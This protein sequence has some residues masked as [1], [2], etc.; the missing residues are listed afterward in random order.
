MNKGVKNH[1]I[2]YIFTDI[3]MD[4]IFTYNFSHIILCKFDVQLAFL[5]NVF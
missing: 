3:Y 1:I 5:G 2:K 4:H